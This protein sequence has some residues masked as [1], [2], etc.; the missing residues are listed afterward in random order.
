MDKSKILVLLVVLIL[1]VSNE[2]SNDDIA[3][4]A[5]VLTWAGDT[6]A[7]ISVIRSSGSSQETEII[8]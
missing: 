6:L 7:V 8:I 5:A 3:A 1:F 2:M 4:L